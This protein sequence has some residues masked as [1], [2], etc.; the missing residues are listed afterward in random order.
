MYNLEL[1][2]VIARI[3]KNNHKTVVIQLPDGLK[4]KAGEIVDAIRESTGAEVIIWMAS[5]YGACDVPMGLEQLK[6]DLIVQWG[7]NKFNKIEG[8]SGDE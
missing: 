1:E 4:P 2:K 8:W 3:K 5:C 7:H 6:A